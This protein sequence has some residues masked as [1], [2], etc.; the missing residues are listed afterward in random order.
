MSYALK[1][2]DGAGIFRVILGQPLEDPTKTL[3][4]ADLWPVDDTIP[5]GKVQ[6]FSAGIGGWFLDAGTVKPCLKDAPAPQVPFS[7]SAL[8]LRL[9]LNSAGL[10]TA[11]E[12][13]IATRANWPSDAAHADAQDRWQF[14]ADV[15]RDS[16][17]VAQLGA[18]LGLNSA[19]IDAAFI[20]AAALS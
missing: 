3:A 2:P 1:T 5:P 9:W 10:R 4:E 8:Q 16:D 7:I 15:L 17:M 12:D 13:I 19:Q 6:D 14:R 18:A 20:A 11:V